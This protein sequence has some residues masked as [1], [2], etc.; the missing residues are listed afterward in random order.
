M[1]LSSL[2]LHLFRLSTRRLCYNAGAILA[3]LLQQS[4][5]DVLERRQSTMLQE[6]YLLVRLHHRPWFDGWSGS[7]ILVQVEGMQ[8][9]GAHARD[10]CPIAEICYR[11]PKQAVGISDFLQREECRTL[12]QEMSHLLLQGPQDAAV[13]RTGAA[14]VEIAFLLVREF[15]VLH[16]AILWHEDAS[17]NTRCQLRCCVQMN[18]QSNVLGVLQERR[19]KGNPIRCR[20]QSCNISQWHT[21]VLLL[22]LK[23]VR[24]QGFKLFLGAVRSG[25]FPE[26]VRLGEQLAICGHFP[27]AT[28]RHVAACLREGFLPS[29]PLKSILY[30]STMPYVRKHVSDQSWHIIRDVSSVLLDPIQDHLDECPHQTGPFRK[31]FP[32]RLRSTLHTAP[33][34]H[35]VNEVLSQE[36]LLLKKHDYSKS[37]DAVFRERLQTH[38]KDTVFRVWGLG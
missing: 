20:R 23:K 14:E 17:P 21:A 1:L 30:D 31:L 37:E 8:R 12:S 19:G 36:L 7:L 24:W 6:W 5:V 10:Y 38:H 27:Q 34:F 26:V 22:W 3:E 25:Y 2:C 29:H 9:T 15:L 13:A 35:E 4:K 11:Q 18:Y 16:D 28:G 32:E 33:A